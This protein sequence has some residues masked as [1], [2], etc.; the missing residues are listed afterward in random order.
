LRGI[1]PNSSGIKGKTRGIGRQTTTRRTE[2]HSEWKDFTERFFY[3]AGMLVN[4]GERHEK[5]DSSHLTN[6]AYINRVSG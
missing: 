4:G 2:I 5:V 6:D 3:G 1:I